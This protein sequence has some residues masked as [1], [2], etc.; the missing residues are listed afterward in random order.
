MLNYERALSF[1][2]YKSVRQS[3]LITCMVKAITKMKINRYL[4]PGC[5]LAVLLLTGCG[6]RGSLYQVPEQ[7]SAESSQSEVA[8]AQEKQKP[9]KLE[10][11]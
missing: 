7:D 9:R 11:N 1:S 10:Q 3:K 4:T 8:A 2:G 5:L 6:L